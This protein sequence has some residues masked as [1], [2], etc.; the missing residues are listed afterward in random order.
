MNGDLP[1]WVANWLGV[2]SGNGSGSAVWQLETAWRW[3]PWATVLLVAGAMLWTTILYAREGS[4]ARAPYRGLLAVLRLITLALL[5]AMLAKWMLAIRITSPP[6]LA[7]LVDRSASMG[8]VD[9]DHGA[10]SDARTTGGAQSAA[11]DH[12]TRLNR[13]KSILTSDD[14]QLLAALA[15]RYRVELVSFAGDI[16]RH[17]I[18]GDSDTIAEAVRAL[19]TDGP[20]S[21]ATRVGDA[22]ARVLA[23]AGGAPPAA[24]VVFSDGV[25]TA[26]MSLE[27]A[28][29][30]ARRQ[31]VPIFAI[32]LGS[33]QAPRDIEIVDLLVDDVVFVN[34]RIRFQIEIKSTGC[35]GRQA[36]VVLRRSGQSQPVA[37]QQIV[38]GATGEMQTV[39]LVDRPT[40]PGEVTYELEIMAS[41]DETNVEN[42]R[43]RRTVSVRDAKIRVLLAYGY[44]SYEFRYL[45]SLL[46]RDSTISLSTYLQEADPDFAAQ[47][48]TA[49]RAL[50]MTRDELFEFDVVIVG[51]INPRLLPRMIWTNLRLL[52]TEKGGGVAFIAGPRYLPWFFSDIDDVAALLPID[53][54]SLSAS[55][56]G[57]A[58]DSAEGFRVRPTSIG[59][60]AASLQLGDSRQETERIW[61][62]LAPL[63][64]LAEINALKPGAQVL[65]E[66][67]SQKGANGRNLP[68]ICF[69]FFGSGRV[70]FHAIDS[71]WRWRIGGGD[72]Y[73][74]RYWVQSIR[75]LARGTLARRSGAEL[76]ADRREYERGQPVT[77]RARLFDKRP[78]NPANSVAVLVESEGQASRRLTL[79]R[80]ASTA[81]VF[82]GV[83]EN[84]PAG[85]YEAIMVEPRPAGE[86]A[87][88]RF[89]VV[90]PPGEFVRTTMDRTAL[91]DATRT[92][93]GKFYTFADADRLLDELP[94]GRRAPIQSMAPISIW[95]QWWLL[96]TFLLCL[97]G[98]WVL[99]KRVGML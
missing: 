22:V 96:A 70:L 82:D 84:L 13:A 56:G 34:D 52:V 31:G 81:Q 32:G 79:S 66:N 30:E 60:Q 46:E 74:A 1:D 14:G 63:Y 25:V 75:T 50:P 12:A 89:T 17:A 40:L 10:E 33:S 92:T 43:A 80:T 83:L 68:A 94:V 71:T 36:R 26:G 19:T 69:Q 58:I 62:N 4:S 35:E 85:Q 86:P 93:R 61:S 3:A 39:Q 9:R 24:I 27:D 65:A 77:L 99:R 44:P 72:K 76:A 55:T 78:T 28:A 59:L 8:I 20:T 49:M 18:D 15:R 87:V 5:L 37:E 41:D 98:E 45:K 11:L 21:G 47:D 91:T 73:F 2:D 97:T 95:N 51:D 90:S 64:W 57:I 38:L 16:E 48:K 67:P 29:T 42:N 88:A 23:T 54:D 53:V 7:I 6:S